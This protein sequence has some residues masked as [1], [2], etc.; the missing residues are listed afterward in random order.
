MQSD[1]RSA[2]VVVLGLAGFRVVA[3]GEDGG[4]IELVVETTA[5]RDWCRG[6]GIRA[7][8]KGRHWVVVRDVG[9]FGRRVRLRWVKRRWRCPEPACE[10]RT[11]TEQSAAIG[12]RRAMTERARASACR[13]VGREGHSVAAVA[14]DTGV[15]WQAIMRAVVDHG[16]PLVDDP[17]RTAGV[18]ALGVD[19]TSFL[20]ASARRHT[21]YVTG[22]V[23]LGRSRLLDGVD[24]RA[25]SAVSSWLADR[26]DAW[27][28]GVQRVALDPYAA[29]TTRWSA[30]LTPPRSSWTR[31]TSCAWATACSTRS[32]GGCSKTPSATAGA[33]TTRCTA[34]GRLLLTGQERLTVRG[35]RRVRA[36]L[37]AGDPPRTS[38][39]P[40]RSKRRYAGCIAPRTKPMPATRSLSSTTW[41]PP[42]AC[43]RP[44]ALLAPSAAGTTKCWPTTAATGSPTHDLRPPTR[45]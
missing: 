42:R 14:R 2:D 6:C 8:S 20:A 3:A 19:E 12:S 34:S 36:G 4:E 28:A 30:G 17:A 32:A 25:G 39:T 22:L 13:R 24:G 43:P 7:L 10:V 41:P 29:T 5:E 21:R 40:G 1:A 37:D 44:P 18:R 33:T 23:D 31:F 26:E 16:R 27:L 9:A 38:G 45:W 11:W 35:W 15:G